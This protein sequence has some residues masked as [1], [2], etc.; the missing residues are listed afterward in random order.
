MPV[1]LPLPRPL[2]LPARAQNEARRWLTL[3]ID[4]D[5][6]AR[7]VL[8]QHLEDLDCDVITAAGADE[9]ISLARRMRPDLITID[10]MMPHKSGIEALHEFKTDPALRDIPVV[11][12]SVVADEHRGR[13]LGAVD[14]LSKP[15]TREALASVLDRNVVGAAAQ[16]VLVLR[17]EN[18]TGRDYQDLFGTRTVRVHVATDAVD[19]Q[20]ALL[21]NAVPSLIVLDVGDPADEILPW[22]TAIRDDRRTLRVPL[23]VMVSDAMAK[24][25]GLSLEGRA[26]VLPRSEELRAELSG[27]IG[28]LRGRAANLAA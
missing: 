24:A 16:S 26:T 2:S 27:V 1:V 3:V 7:V 19:A 20:R 18:A 5:P 4:D 14:C 28:A 21:G 17:K 22:I 9:G 11:V 12:V 10:V 25:T 15:V 6:D 23:V 8:T 13:V